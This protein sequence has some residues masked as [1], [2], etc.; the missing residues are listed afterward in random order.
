MGLN[1]YKSFDVK[2]GLRTVIRKLI[3]FQ[4]T[5]QLSYAEADRRKLH[6]TPFCYKVEAPKNNSDSPYTTWNK[7]RR[8]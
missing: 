3:G 4:K 5:S 2:A 1:S 8:R 7:R 6:L